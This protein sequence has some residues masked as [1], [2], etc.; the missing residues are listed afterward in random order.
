MG[1]V[2]RRWEPIYDPDCTRPWWL[3]RPALFVACFI[4]GVVVTLTVV[5]L[6]G[7]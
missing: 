2:G 6:G 5:L 4:S 7:V 3:R 1:C